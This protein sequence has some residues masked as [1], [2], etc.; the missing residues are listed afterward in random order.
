MVLDSMKTSHADDVKTA[1]VH[2]RLQR[3]PEAWIHTQ[4]LH[5]NLVRGHRWIVLQN[6]AAIEFGNREAEF[7]R[8][9]FHVQIIRAH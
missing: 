6:V 5:N 7:A 1:V 4:M 9:Q 3:F 8:L 2:S